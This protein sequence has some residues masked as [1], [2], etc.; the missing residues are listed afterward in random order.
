MGIKGSRQAVWSARAFH[1]LISIN[2]NR[3]VT[4]YGEARGRIICSSRRALDGSEDG[5]MFSHPAEERTRGEVTSTQA[6][7]SRIGKLSDERFR[8]WFWHRADTKDH[9]SS[10]LFCKCPNILREKA[11]GSASGLRP[12][13]PTDPDMRI[14]RIRLFDSRLRYVTEEVRNIPSRT[15]LRTFRYP[16]EFR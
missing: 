16:P 5:K 15:R 14:S 6:R 10:D 7:P 11:V 4:D 12:E 2:R 1:H 3:D 8:R 13:A 9:R